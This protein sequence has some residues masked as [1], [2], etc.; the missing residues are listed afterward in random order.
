MEKKKTELST[1]I[2]PLKK[3]T[4]IINLN[5]DGNL[6]NENAQW[7]QEAGTILRQGGTVIFPTETVYGLGGNALDPLAAKEI[8]RAKGRPSDNP[9]IIHISQKDELTNLVEEIGKKERLLMEAFWPGPL[10]IIFKKSDKVPYETT[11]GLDTVA[12]RMPSNE[13]ARALIEEARVP[14]AAPSANLSGRPSI[15]CGDFVRE[16]MNERVDM[17][18]IDKDS[19]IG[20]ES[21]VIDMTGDTPV[22]LRPGKIS[23]REI[24]SVLGEMI[25]LESSSEGLSEDSVAVPK[26]PGM[27]YRHYSP[28]ATIIVVTG[29]EDERQGKATR[30]IHEI[31]GQG[32]K[33]KVLTLS[34][35]LS[36][37]GND[38][39]DLGKDLEE[40]AKNLF[41]AFRR[42]DQ[43][44]LDYLIVESLYGDELAEA[45]MNR[46][47]K[48][49]GNNII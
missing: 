18:I 17:I 47:K 13:I 5:E 38:G 19:E 3:K 23:K 35:R 21:T 39:M 43:E 16:E 24:E 34:D 25:R 37:Y 28:T 2:I 11:G 48:A 46:I 36:L 9:L 45:I 49:A 1:E 33:A 29:T 27:K 30:K 12:I 8:Y 31:M 7:L 40:V 4:Q 32:K 10:T 44:K 20:L 42:A 6:P 14:V 22:I 15:T 26:A 41:T